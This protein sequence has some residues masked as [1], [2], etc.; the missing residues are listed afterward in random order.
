MRKILGKM[1]V[2]C[3]AA[4]FVFASVDLTARAGTKSRAERREERI[5]RFAGELGLSAEQRAEINGIRADSRNRKNN[6]VENL[7]QARRTLREELARPEIDRAAIDR[8][9]SRIKVLQSDLVDERVES[10]LAMKEVMTEQQFRRMTE[11]T[12]SWRD[13]G[14]SRSGRRSGRN[15]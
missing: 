5:D 2:C 13:K 12:E 15:E 14:D 3:L 10:F 8:A 9:A 1:T 11:I 7:R 4:L 6:I